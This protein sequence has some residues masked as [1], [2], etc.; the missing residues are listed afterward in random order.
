MISYPHRQ[1]HFW[2]GVLFL[3]AAMLVLLYIVLRYTPSVIGIWT[4]GLVVAICVMR[5]VHKEYQVPLILEA[6]KMTVISCAN[7]YTVAYRDIMFIQ[8][9]GIPRCFLG[10]MMV[11]HCGMQGKIYVDASYENYISL[12]CEIV[13]SARAQNSRVMISP[14]M[15]K[16][17]KM[18]K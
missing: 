4:I 3:C 5:R 13:E 8:Y 7:T 1:K 10:D 6:E 2:N 18:K 17:L 12:W 14:Y 11:L 9:R 15:Q 16:R